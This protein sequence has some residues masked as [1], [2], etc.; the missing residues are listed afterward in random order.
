MPVGGI[1]ILVAVVA[2][3]ARAI[4]RFE[5]LCL[6]ELAST[7]DLELR[8]LN[9]TGWTVAILLAIPLGGIVYLYAGRVP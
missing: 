1:V 6:R 3:A 8:Y 4:T 2:V 9:R 7:P 5:L